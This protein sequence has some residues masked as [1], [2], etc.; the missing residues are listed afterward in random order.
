MN[1][2]LL[3]AL[4]ALLPAVLLLAA[5]VTLFSKA[6]PVPTF[7]QL[8]GAG[9][10]TVVVLAHGTQCIFD[11]LISSVVSLAEDSRISVVRFAVVEFGKGGAICG[12]R[13]SNRT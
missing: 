3:K 9:C 1:V 10:L 2:T 12:E 11:R 13:S 4:V 5:S 7:L 8:V 6:K